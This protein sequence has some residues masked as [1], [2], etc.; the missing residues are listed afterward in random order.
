MGLDLQLMLN[1]G[2]GLDFDLGKSQGE[3][4]GYLVEG[5]LRLLENL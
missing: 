3:F 2:L 1:L 5:Q 4:N